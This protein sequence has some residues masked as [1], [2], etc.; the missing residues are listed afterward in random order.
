MR[1]KGSF[2]VS[3]YALFDLSLRDAIV[4]LLQKDWKGIEIMC[5]ENHADLLDWSWERLK[6]LK[7]Q[8][9]EGEIAWSIHAPIS[10]CNLAADA[11]STR[12]QTL[13]TMKRCLEIASFLDCTHV[14]MHA[15]EV[16]DRLA[17]SERARGVENVSQAI[18]VLTSE[19]SAES[20]TILTVENV[21]PYPKVLGWNVEDLVRICQHVDSSRVR[22]VYDVGHAH[23]IRPG[24]AIDAL[25]KVLPYLSALHLSDNFGK[26]DDH[27]AVGE[28]TIPFEPILSLLKD[29]GFAGHWVVETKQLA[30][31]EASVE[32]LLRAGGK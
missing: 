13:N 9:N 29:N 17:E 22:I 15:G 14:V 5:E 20:R 16:E 26:L 4:Q 2:S 18:H 24:Y 10:G 30:C 31:A 11:G 6:E 12:D 25:Q 27:L 23:L 7:Q 21:P 1:D 3:T 8:G 19:L 28:G 32:R